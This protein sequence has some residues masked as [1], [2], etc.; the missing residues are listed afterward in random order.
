METVY[1]RRTK[2]M[3]GMLDSKNRARLPI[4]LRLA[5]GT[6]NLTSDSLHACGK[7]EASVDVD[8]ELVELDANCR[9]PPPWP[10]KR[11]AGAAALLCN[12][13]A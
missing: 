7:A 5:T 8:V 13:S 11:L 6:G 3:A 9:L 4:A 12:R 10:A 1:L 2:L